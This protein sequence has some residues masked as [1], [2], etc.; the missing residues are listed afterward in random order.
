MEKHRYIKFFGD[1]VDW[2]VK[3]ILEIDT[4]MQQNFENEIE[5]K[6]KTRPGKVQKNS[7]CLCEKEYEIDD[8]KGNPVAE[9]HRPVRGKLR[10]LAHDRYNL[11]T[12]KNNV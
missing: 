5:I 8:K 6:P 10:G 9:E 4:F 2:S 7:C 12:Q 11:G 3:E 1:W